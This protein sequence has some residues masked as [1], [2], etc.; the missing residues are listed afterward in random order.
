MDIQAVIK[1]LN[2]RGFSAEYCENGAAAKARA[3]EIIGQKSAGFGGS[4]T[5]DGLGL[6]ETLQAEGK[7]AYYHLKKPAEERVAE[8]NRALQADVY[9]CS[10]N[11]LLADGRLVNIDGTGN[12]LS[13]TIYGPKT[14]IV[15]AG[16]NKIVEGT[17]DDAI[18]R[19]KAVACPLNARRLGRKTPCALT[20]KCADCRTKERICA[21]T[22]VH[23]MPTKHQEKFYVLVTDEDMGY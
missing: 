10:V 8:R 14:V 15:I 17:L 13:G 5:V 21:V 4:M 9:I 12:R 7:E 19:V 3:L 2:G 11:A 18:A 22:S 1:N 23:E 16:R 20:G 6:Y